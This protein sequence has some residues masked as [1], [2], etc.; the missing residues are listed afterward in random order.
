MTQISSNEIELEIPPEQQMNGK[1]QNQEASST[2]F[3]SAENGQSNSSDS[4][5]WIS[6]IFSQTPVI[7]NS[8]RFHRLDTDEST[9]GKSNSSTLQT[10]TSDSK[11]RIRRTKSWR[12]KFQYFFCC[13]SP[14]TIDL[15]SVVEFED[16]V[17]LGQEN[18]VE[19]LLGVQSEKNKGKKTLVLDLDETMVH[20]SFREV[21]NPD[22][23]LPVEVEGALTDVFVLKRPHLDYFM[24]QVSEKYEVV[25]FTASLSKYADPL[26]D[27]LDGKKNIDGRL[28]RE[29]CVYYSGAYVKDLSKLGRDLKNIIIV[30]NSP[31]SYIFQPENAIPIEAFI[32]SMEDRALVDLLPL[33]MDLS[34]SADVRDGLKQ[35]QRSLL[36]GTMGDN[37]QQ[38]SPR[39]ST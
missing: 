37:V 35:W 4:S 36:N 7:S 32:D 22:Y 23:V 27:L 38:Y 33:L 11:L 2:K 26:L 18:D 12:K 5:Q 15:S 16:G 25:V 24:D 14:T 34:A 28:F 10:T 3:H 9:N 31:N 21:E 6:N 1:S 30:D 17:M 29:H 13:F 19:N 8:K 20:S 39:H